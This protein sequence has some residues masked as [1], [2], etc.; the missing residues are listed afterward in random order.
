MSPMPTGQLYQLETSKDKLVLLVTDYNTQCI[1]AS[2]F[3]CT[4][5]MI[6]LFLTEKNSGWLIR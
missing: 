4:V 1:T 3:D 2:D 5:E 6:S